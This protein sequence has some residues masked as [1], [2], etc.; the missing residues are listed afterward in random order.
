MGAIVGIILSSFLVTALIRFVE[1]SVNEQ[2]AADWT[3]RYRFE[4]KCRRQAAVIIQRF[5]REYAKKKKRAR[6]RSYPFRCP[7]NLDETDEISDADVM[8]KAIRSVKYH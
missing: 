5:W 4:L 1:M 8:L 3:G 7:P 6:R 2:V